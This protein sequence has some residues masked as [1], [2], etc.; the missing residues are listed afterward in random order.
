LVAD[1]QRLDED[2]W[3]TPSLCGG[4]TVRDVVAHM[5]AAANMTP[6]GFFA[7]LLGS[8]FSFER[9]QKKGISAERGGSPADTLD[10]FSSLADSERH[11]PG[12]TDTMLGETLIH[13]QDVRVPL[14][15]HHDYP[16]NAVVQVADFY[17]GSN[18]LIGAKRRIAG[19]TLRSTDADWSHGTGPEVSG[20][21]LA[22][23]MAMT[24]R[25]AAVDELTGEGVA[26]LRG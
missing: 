25:T 7:K 1:L 12:S 4:W 21:I 14:G 26:K 16:T 20:P 18:L 15:I 24:G 5:S 11:P 9:V 2:Q 6:P 22:L 3:S 10:R 13:A 19:V 23:V 8:G 17:K